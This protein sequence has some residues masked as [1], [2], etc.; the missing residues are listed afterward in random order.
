M[1]QEVIDEVENILMMI[2]ILYHMQQVIRLVEQLTT[3]REETD[4]WVI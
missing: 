3:L 4:I 1:E 2:S